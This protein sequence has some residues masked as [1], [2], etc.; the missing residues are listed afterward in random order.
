MA[1]DGYGIVVQMQ[2][3]EL[4]QHAPG[5]RGYRLRAEAASLHCDRDSNAWTI[6]IICDDPSGLSA[7]RLIEHS[8]DQYVSDQDKPVGFHQYNPNEAEFLRQIWMYQPKTHR[9]IA[10]PYRIEQ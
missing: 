6:G 9:F 4:A 5:D 1:A 8:P 3:E 10:G 2:V 7:S